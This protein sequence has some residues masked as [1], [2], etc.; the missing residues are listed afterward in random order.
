MYTKQLE[1][2]LNNTSTNNFENT[3]ISI[4]PKD[5]K[6]IDEITNYLDNYKDTIPY[7]NESKILEESTNTMLNSITII[8][9]LIS[10]ISLIVSSIM[11]G[12]ITYINVLERKKEIGI[13]KTLGTSKK[14]I[15]KLF[16]LESILIGFISSTLGI[17]MSNLISI[18]INKIVYNTTSIINISRLNITNIITIIILSSILSL[19]GGLLSSKKA[20]KLDVSDLLI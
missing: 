13:L 6:S 8:L 9:L 12:I 20:S 2:Y 16:N 4:Y 18:P 7:I 17:T 5:F 15:R 14:E 10:S 11:Q 19:L 3:L 1:E